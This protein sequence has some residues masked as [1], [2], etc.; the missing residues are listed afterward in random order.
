MSFNYKAPKYFSQ[1]ENLKDKITLFLI[2][3]YVP[4]SILGNLA[5]FSED[6][7]SLGFSSIILFLVVLFNFTKALR[8]CLKY[9]L[10]FSIF[11]LVFWWSFT[12]LFSFTYSQ[13]YSQLMQFILYLFFSSIVYKFNWDI[14]RVQKIFFLY[15]LGSFITS[16]FTIIDFLKIIDIPRVNETVYGK[17]TSIGTILQASG[18]F[19]RR[20]AM[21]AYFSISIPICFFMIIWGEIKYIIIKIFIFFTLFFSII[22][23]MITGNRAA[24]FGSFISIVIILILKS[25]N[26]LILF[27]YLISLII[28][29][30]IFIILLTIYFPDQMIV[31]KAILGLG[32][33]DLYKVEEQSESDQIRLLLFLHV[34]Q[35]FAE[36]PLGH[37]FSNIYNFQDN[38]NADPHNIITQILW[39]S[40]ILGFIWI[41]FFFKF[42]YLKL[43]NVFKFNILCNENLRIYLIILISGLLSWIICGMY[44]MIL[45]MGIA[46]LFFGILL[47]ISIKFKNSITT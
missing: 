26:K 1:N 5:K 33:V 40:G 16:S 46:W 9:K 19:S 34:I 2:F 32:D 8:A 27:K 17:E 25:R 10:Y 30:F 31:Y 39:A 6:E 29:I 24:I 37:G 35:S 41:S 43:K 13:A 44:H 47:N 21:A 12:S 11:L 20:S 23:L 15:I 45:G 4:L 28:F 18:P 36:N 38:D 3:L 42:I 22:S 14:S 7:S